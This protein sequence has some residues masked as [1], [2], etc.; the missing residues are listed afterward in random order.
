[1]EKGTILYQICVE[2]KRKHF[3][4][5]AKFSSRNVYLKEPTQE[6]I[7]IFIEKCTN[8][9]HPHNLYD[10]EKEGLKIKILKLIIE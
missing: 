9:E 10:L 1:M 8:S 3:D 6:Q 4:S 7:N 5:T 2:G